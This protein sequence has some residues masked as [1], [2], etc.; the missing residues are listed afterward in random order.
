MSFGV[1][2]A[3][4]IALEGVAE[5]VVVVVAVFLF[6]WDKLTPA[7]L[8][9]DGLVLLFGEVLIL[10]WLSRFSIGGLCLWLPEEGLGS[11]VTKEEVLF[12]EFIGSF[13]SLLESGGE[14]DG[15]MLFD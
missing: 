2:R 4:N 5:R 1:L 6:K 7:R 12:D 10:V 8:A 11:G 14:A 13:S 15:V 9:E 3:G